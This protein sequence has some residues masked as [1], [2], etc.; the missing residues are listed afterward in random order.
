MSTTF[1]REDVRR[2]RRERTCCCCHRKRIRVGDLYASVRGVM[3]GGW[4]SDDWCHRCFRVYR[5]IY[6]TDPDMADLWAHEG[7]NPPQDIRDW[8]HEHSSRH[9]Q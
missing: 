5:R 8:L 2:S 1:Y 7:I 9:R 6:L 3:D 4:W